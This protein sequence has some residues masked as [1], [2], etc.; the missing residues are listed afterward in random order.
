[1]TDAYCAIWDAKWLL[2]AVLMEVMQEGRR[3]VK[4]RVF[5]VKLAPRS[6]RKGAN[7]VNL[8]ASETFFFLLNT[9]TS[10]CPMFIAYFAGDVHYFVA[11]M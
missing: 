6:N 4:R 9:T 11:A 1:M 5:A 2:M 7:R 8:D 3:R 10:R